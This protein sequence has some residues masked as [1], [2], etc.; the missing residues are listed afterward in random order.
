[1]IDV[2]FLPWRH[3]LSSVL[4]HSTNVD[5]DVLRLN[6]LGEVLQRIKHLVAKVHVYCFQ[7]PQTMATLLLPSTVQGC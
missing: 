1:M 4:H 7:I 5:L 3:N 2:V 6:D